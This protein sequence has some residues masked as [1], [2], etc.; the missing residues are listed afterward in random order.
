[1]K[2]SKGNCTNSYNTVLCFICMD[3]GKQVEATGE[4]KEFQRPSSALNEGTMDRD[5][6]GRPTQKNSG[7]KNWA[8]SLSS[9]VLPGEF[10]EEGQLLKPRLKS[11]KWIYPWALLSESP[12]ER[13]IICLSRYLNLQPPDTHT[14]QSSLGYGAMVDELSKLDFPW[15]CNLDR[16]WIKERK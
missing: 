2:K 1:M 13:H 14:M 7:L 3:K 5:R 15:P 16:W 4:M 11:N 6:W 9:L 10:S 12:K 8:V